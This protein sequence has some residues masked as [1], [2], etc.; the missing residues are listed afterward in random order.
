M[1]LE[2]SIVSFGVLSFAALA[3]A[4][5]LYIK[6]AELKDWYSGRP[7]LLRVFM[8][9][10]CFLQLI[11]VTGFVAYITLAIDHHQGKILVD[12]LCVCVVTLDPHSIYTIYREAVGPNQ[13]F[14]SGDIVNKS[15]WPVS[16]VLYRNRLIA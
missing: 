6:T 10:G 12:C 1:H 15:G 8:Y 16:S 14:K 13:F 7:Q 3:A 4:L 2:L 11:G 9:C 5:V